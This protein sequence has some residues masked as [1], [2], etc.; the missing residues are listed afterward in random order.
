[1]LGETEMIL[2][3]NQAGEQLTWRHWFCGTGQLGD[4]PVVPRSSQS[5]CKRGK[6]D[7]VW[8]GRS[9]KL[10]ILLKTFTVLR[11]V[12]LYACGLCW[13][14]TKPGPIPVVCAWFMI[15]FL[16]GQ[17]PST[18]FSLSSSLTSPN[19]DTSRTHQCLIYSIV[20][21]VILGWWM[22]CLTWFNRCSIPLLFLFFCSARKISL[23]FKCS[24]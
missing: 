18:L 6:Q 12:E 17:V 16:E 3:Q 8:E 13:N 22:S 24:V 11:P 4:S 21:K 5:R 19:T 20:L 1:M 14:W 9:R 7:W 15:V 10:L 23:L 2:I